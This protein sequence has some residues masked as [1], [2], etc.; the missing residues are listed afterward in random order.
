MFV[1]SQ[2]A[3]SV[4]PNQLIV[5]DDVRVLL[6]SD[7]QTISIADDY[8]VLSIYFPHI[9]LIQTIFNSKY[10]HAYSLYFQHLICCPI[11]IFFFRVFLANKLFFSHY[12]IWY[13]PFSY[14]N[15]S[16]FNLSFSF[17]MFPIKKFNCC[18][19]QNIC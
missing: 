11:S 6:I 15:V 4:A 5:D 7:I 1:N 12:D 18:E 2:L 8:L 17:H 3:F 14:I 9:F 19:K 16:M 13:S 10:F